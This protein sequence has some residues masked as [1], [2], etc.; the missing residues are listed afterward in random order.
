M[1]KQKLYI[2]VFSETQKCVSEKTHCWNHQGF[3]SNNRIPPGAAKWRRR[4]P[5]PYR[6]DGETAANTS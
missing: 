1:K 4:C 5:R 6:N 2:S 3:F